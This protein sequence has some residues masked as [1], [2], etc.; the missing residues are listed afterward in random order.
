MLW[1]DAVPV[2][3]VSPGERLLLP[4]L[5]RGRYAVQWRTVLGDAWDPGGVVTCPGL[6]EAGA[7]RVPGP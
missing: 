2:A 1:V 3:W 7:A 5:V 6:S 4:G